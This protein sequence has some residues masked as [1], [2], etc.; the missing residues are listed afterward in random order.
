MQDGPSA[1]VNGEILTI[2]ATASITLVDGVWTNGNITFDQVLPVGDYNIV[3]MRAE[4]TG[5]VAARLVIQGY[6]WRPG[7]VGRTTVAQDDLDMMR[8]GRSGVLGTF[9]NNVPPTLDAIGATGTTQVI[10]LDLIKV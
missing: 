6:P 9:N 8:F 3:G 5:L 1:P 10:Y 7:I 4:G 2:R